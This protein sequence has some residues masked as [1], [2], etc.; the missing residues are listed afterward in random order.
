MALAQRAR[1]RR[2]LSVAL[3][4]VVLSSLAGCDCGRGRLVAANGGAIR[5]TL[6]GADPEA[7]TLQIHLARL[8]QASDTS[9]PISSLPLVTVLDQLAPGMYRAKVTAWDRRPS[10]LQSVEVTDISVVIGGMTDITIDLSRMVVHPAEQ[11]DGVDNDGDEAIDEGLDLPVCVACLDGGTSVLADDE[12]CG[13]VRCDGLD[14][15]Q[16]RGVDTVGGQSTC[17]KLQ[18]APVTTN[19]CAGV[20]ACVAPNGPACDDET[21]VLV[22]RKGVCQVMRGC[23]E[24][25]P[26]I[27]WV[28]EGTPCAASSICLGGAC[29]PVVPD[30]GAPDA[31]NP[32][33]PIGCSDGTREGFTSLGTYPDIAACAGGWTVPGVTAAVGPACSR[34]SGNGAA[35]RDGAGCSSADLCSAGWHVCRG[36]DEVALKAHGSCADAVPAG[37]PN[38]SLFFA[39]VQASQSNTTCDTSGDNDVFG[40]GNLGT[41]LSAGKNC[42]VLTRALASTRAG[43]CGFNEAEPNLG[44]W[45]CVGGAQGDLHE[46]AIV[47]KQGCPS[48]SC[49]YDGNPVGN[50][51][52]GGVLCCRD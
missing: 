6:V 37:A 19:R 42:G 33:D 3:L 31:G 2:H 18:H 22:A 26:S 46:G 8:D 30:A 12:R 21:E 45:Q 38:N 4:A 48:G 52:K 23:A 32:V 34:R 29:V 7:V 51:D 15:W 43:T 11:C 10:A 50:A 25:S 17:V 5:V 44:P 40:C 24:G 47:T 36:K 14:S 28:P 9:V 20:G 39:V 13:T 41:Q 35:N 16:V 27:E 1:M 49:S